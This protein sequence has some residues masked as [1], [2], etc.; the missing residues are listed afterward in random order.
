MRCWN[1]CWPGH[2]EAALAGYP[3]ME[4]AVVVL[5]PGRQTNRPRTSARD[6]SMMLHMMHIAHECLLCHGWLSKPRITKPFKT[7][8]KRLAWLKRPCVE[9]SQTLRLIP[10]HCIGTSF[11]NWP[12]R[13]VS[14]WH[15][16]ISFNTRAAVFD[17]GTDASHVCAGIDATGLTPDTES[18]LCWETQ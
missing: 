17:A 8:C 10:F 9:G 16:I 15:A 11:T 4:L 7:Q 12:E 14:C 13:S 5:Q 3:S 18:K 1:T 2:R 6:A